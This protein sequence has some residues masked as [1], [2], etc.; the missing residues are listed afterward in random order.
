MPMIHVSCDKCRND[1]D[2]MQYWQ[3]VN[4]RLIMCRPCWQRSVDTRRNP[5]GFWQQ[6]ASVMA[7]DCPNCESYTQHRVFPLRG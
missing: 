7:W 5:Q 2:G 1:H 4:C 6:V 3:C